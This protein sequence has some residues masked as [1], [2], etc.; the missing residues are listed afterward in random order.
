MSKLGVFL[1]VSVLLLT[2]CGGGGGGG[3]SS[4]S[5]VNSRG[6]DRI[7]SISGI[8]T[9]VLG[10][11]MTLTEIAYRQN[12]GFADEV[13]IATSD[14]I[15]DF[16]L[17]LAGEGTVDVSSPPP[18]N[19]T[20]FNIMPF[21]ISMTIF[22]GEQEWAYT[23][24]CTGANGLT[25][26]CSNINFDSATRTITL[27]DVVVLAATSAGNLA[28]GPLTINGKITWVEGD[29][30]PISSTNTGGK[31]V[32]EGALTNITGVWQEDDPLFYTST[33]GYADEVYEVYKQDGTNLTFAYYQ[34]EGCYDSSLAMYQDFGSGNIAIGGNAPYKFTIAANIM[35][36]SYLG[37]SY[38]L[39]KS[40]FTEND[41]VPVCA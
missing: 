27:T 16:V 3:T 33:L 24:A 20:V 21:G 4:G 17:A 11:K 31:P 26:N 36:V 22:K 39:T 35:T 1:I 23:L 32:V 28:S 34:S 14:G 2:A 9:T 19:R 25:V 7:L 38:T 5:V 30:K 13:V 6:Q 18:I 15:L 41:F 10:D 37:N 8:D 12:F 29:E 40:T